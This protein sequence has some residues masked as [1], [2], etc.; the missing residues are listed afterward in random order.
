MWRNSPPNIN[1]LVG[2][3][4]HLSGDQ[5]DKLKQLL[6][7]YEELFDGTLGAWKTP[8][9]SVELK[10]GAN[11]HHSKPYPVLHIHNAQFKEDLDA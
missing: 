10:E 6:T 7:S 11:P 4:Y 1:K 8:P 2:G 9:I 5:K 3:Y